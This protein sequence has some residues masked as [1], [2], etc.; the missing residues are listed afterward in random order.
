MA[1]RAPLPS[2]RPPRILVVKTTSMGDVVHALPAVSDIARA[3]PGAVIDWLVEAPFAA[4]PAAHP[5]VCKVMP[6]AWRKWR[7]SL[8]KPETR[9]AIAA[10][11]RELQAERYDLVIDFQGLLKSV[12]WA[13]QAHGPRA[14]YDWHSIREPLASLFYAHKASVSRDAHAVVRNR[15]LAA[16]HLGYARPTDTP[17]FGLKPPVS[18]W[19]APKPY[20]VLI[21]CASRPEKLW[22]EDRWAHLARRIRGLGWTPVILWGSP[23]EQALAQRLAEG[24]DAGAVVPPFLSVADAGAVLAGARVVVGLDTGFTHLAAAHARPTVGIYCDH[25]PGLAGVTGS[26]HVRSFGGKGQV[27]PLAEVEAA[28]DEAVRHAG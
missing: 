13:V 9:A 22:P 11:R 25:E 4:I 3:H 8:G 12:L 14:G 18:S 1:D 26:G 15:A 24:S 28:L 23:A 5:A 16:D 7:K 21:P 27:P 17:D 2:G 19:Q 6:V 10:L 20:A